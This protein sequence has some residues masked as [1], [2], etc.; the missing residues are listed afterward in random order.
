V[1]PEKKQ[2]LGDA[3]REAVDALKGYVYQLYQSAIAWIDL[4]A[5]D[6]L[7]LEVAEDYAI[8]TGNALQ[9]VQ[10]KAVAA[11]CTLNT[12]GVVQAIESMLD[13]VQKN[14]HYDVSVRYLSTASIGL[15]KKLEDQVDGGPA[16]ESWK[17]LA[18]SGDPKGLRAVLQNSK[19]KKST[20]EYISSLSDIQFR[21]QVL[22]KVHFDCGAPLGS[23]LQRF[24]RSKF[25][26]LV[27]VEG[28][29]HS[30]ME[31]LETAVLHH[32][33]LV[34]SGQGKRSVDR[35][36]LR[37]LVDEAVR[38][39]V[40]QVDLDRQ[41]Q[42]LNSLIAAAV[43][44]SLPLRTHDLSPVRKI[45]SLPS[46]QVSREALLGSAKGVLEKCGIVWLH[47]A[48]GVG[49]T[50]LARMI[51]SQVGGN[52]SGATLRG[53]DATQSALVLEA[54][55]DELPSLKPDGLII[56]D[57]EDGLAQSTA[58]TFQY[59]FHIADR[60]SSPII[61]TSSHPASSKL[62]LAIGVSEEIFCK[63]P[64]FSEEDIGNI[65]QLFGGNP[66]IWKRYV[67]LASG[68]GHPQLAHGLILNLKQREWPREELRTL[69][70]LLE[71]NPAIEEERLVCRRRLLKELPTGSL[72]LLQR[73]SLH[74]GNF[75]RR[76]A[77]DISSV[78]P[79]IPN[80]GFLL[81]DL[82]GPWVDQP[83]PDHLELS[84]LL[85]GLA[86]H[87]LTEKEKKSV[88]YAIATSLTQGKLFNV[89]EM[90]AGVFSALLSQNETAG[91][92]FCLAIL[93]APNEQLEGIANYLEV[94]VHLKPEIPPW[95]KNPGLNQMFRGAQLLL[96]LYSRSG[97]RYF[98]DALDLF[99]SETLLIA[100]EK[101]RAPLEFIIYTKLL[102]FRVA[103]S[104]TPNFLALVERLFFLRRN[105]IDF[106]PAEIED[107]LSE[108]AGVPFVGF[109][110]ILQVNGIK[111][112]EDLLEVF[113]F[114]NTAER[115]LK[116]ELLLALDIPEFGADLVR[117]AWLAED[118]AG[119]ID[120]GRH[121]KLLEE[122]ENI[123]NDWPR[124][125]VAIICRKYR[126]IILDEYGKLSNEALET[127]DEG[128]QLYGVDNPELMRAK[129]KVLYRLDD[130]DAHLEISKQLIAK[131][132]LSSN[133][134]R[135]FLGR[136]A[137]ISAEKTGD[138]ATAR[139]YYFYAREAAKSSASSDL[140]PMATGLLADASL[141]AWHA[142]DTRACIDELAQVLIEIEDVD[143]L[144][145]LRS[146]HVRA[147]S[148]HILLWL[149]QETSGIIHV[150]EGGNAVRIYPGCVS[151]P[152]PNAEI[153]KREVISVEISYYM[154]SKIECQCA[155]D[156]VVTANLEKYLPHGRILEGEGLLLMGL[157]GRAL[158]QLDP[159]NFY[160]AWSGTMDELAYSARGDVKWAFNL[161]EVTYGV[162]PQILP[163]QFPLFETSGQLNI[164]LFCGLCVVQQAPKIV[165]LIIDI[166]LTRKIPPLDNKF[167]QCLTV[168]GKGVNFNENFAILIFSECKRISRNV[169][170]AP[171]AVCF[172]A[173]YMA[174]AMHY[175]GYSRFISEGVL[176]WYKS[177][178]RR[179]LDTQ[180]FQ[181]VSPAI[182]VPDVES[183][184]TLDTKESF[185]KFLDLILATLPLV[186]LGGPSVAKAELQ[187][188]QNK[189]K[190]GKPSSNL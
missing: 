117:G 137:A 6:L 33:L 149:D 131:N 19:L 78:A 93:Q 98:S 164:L 61:V 104:A 45:P 83:D 187:E 57:F 29:T 163:E 181:L 136:E 63:I 17:R 53:F 120:S 171:N 182:Y 89:S 38:V 96:C 30:Q 134:E 162:F 62:R 128:L 168:G 95:P 75:T 70:S 154:L 69:V 107:Q 183:R 92:K 189:I 87:S 43:P 1:T 73:L 138:Y 79:A 127:L 21:D 59:L 186:N 44:N 80:A 175:S 74:L 22:R 156:L 76:L 167:I 119:T 180:R 115:D 46:L 40:K 146:A 4:G 14:P 49:K 160:K 77:L 148:Q 23:E 101:A 188:I 174:C 24:A 157:F 125:D 130:H 151:N 20:K 141:A 147:L 143:R 88:H 140:I 2:I 5:T 159:I 12:N 122:L 42:L 85:S 9:A 7:G 118:A 169:V 178:W 16:L 60:I 58:D 144:S 65:I 153:A 82:I 67:Y 55:A 116:E 145:S 170:A 51:A 50:T 177:C 109:A 71:G 126:A 11:S 39:S 110:F 27:E 91:T 102:M 184:L 190:S 99:Q 129:A 94:L 179:I 176:V 32:L 52:W 84:P 158:R 142:G 18:K 13:L 68:G 106:F 113:N 132:V 3:R 35:S 185:P 123:A 150:I 97:S 26:H 56:D 66:E 155:L 54:I 100:D 173:Y 86:Q 124:I 37:K 135:A 8:L 36:D 34:C 48:T 161:R 90:Q 165:G 121:T 25:L 152:D 47:G 103:K 105:L 81:D 15:E 64:D 114:V 112:I 166:I 41:I 28:G 133:V 72:A 139:K 111:K 172:Y 108:M 31:M 10:V